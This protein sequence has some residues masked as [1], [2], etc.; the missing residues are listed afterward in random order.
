[1]LTCGRSKSATATI[2]SS[3]KAVRQYL[4]LTPVGSKGLFLLGAYV[5]HISIALGV[6]PTAVE[7]ERL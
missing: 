7:C 6:L 5:V 3:A 1:M 2:S 4:K